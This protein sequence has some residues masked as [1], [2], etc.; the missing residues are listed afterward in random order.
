MET[1]A[2]K[3]FLT[4][5]AEQWTLTEYCAGRRAFSFAGPFWLLEQLPRPLQSTRRWR[6]LLLDLIP[7]LWMGASFSLCHGIEDV[8][9]TWWVEIYTCSRKE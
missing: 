3:S 4:D 7:N 1:G 2:F 6:H 9:A 5:I 8:G